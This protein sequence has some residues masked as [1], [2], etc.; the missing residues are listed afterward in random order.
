MIA[1]VRAVFDGEALHPEQAVGLQPNATYVITIE[2]EA[3]PSQE[4]GDYPLTRIG[5]LAQ[6]MGVADL[7][8]SH[9]RYAHGQLENNRDGA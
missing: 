5:R 3:S 8:T 2:R 7:S 1:T 9:D 6:D 4:S